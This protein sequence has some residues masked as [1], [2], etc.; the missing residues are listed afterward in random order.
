MFNLFAVF[1]TTLV[2]SSA[3]SSLECLLDNIILWSGQLLSAFSKYDGPFHHNWFDDDVV[4]SQWRVGMS[5]GLI[6]VGT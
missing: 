1:V 3:T 6:V 2:T 5:A 4:V